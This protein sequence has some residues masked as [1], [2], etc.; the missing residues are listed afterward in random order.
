MTYEE[1]R[2]ILDGLWEEAD[3]RDQEMKG[4]YPASAALKKRVM[5]ASHAERELFERVITSWLRSRNDNK[6]YDALT[7]IDELDIRSA[8]PEMKRVRRQLRVKPWR[9]DDFEL[10]D[11]AIRYMETSRANGR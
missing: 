11:D 1:A 6:L 2:E 9:F 7:L 8:L 4:A 5:Q 10:L 3:R